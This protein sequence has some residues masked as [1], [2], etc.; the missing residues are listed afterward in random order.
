MD[1][2]DRIM[3]YLICIA[4]SV[5]ISTMIGLLIKPILDIIPLNTMK[6]GTAIVTI[7]IAIQF[8][9]WGIPEAQENIATMP[10]WEQWTYALII[11]VSGSITIGAFLVCVR[12]AED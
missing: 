3:T 11:L 7:P 12:F 2:G 5:F 4:G 10:A 1:I 6:I 9:A 8:I